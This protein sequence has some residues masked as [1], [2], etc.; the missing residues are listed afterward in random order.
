[1]D[2]REL[3]TGASIYNLFHFVIQITISD[4][5]FLYNFGYKNE[6]SK[7]YCIFVP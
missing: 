7:K 5:R 4:G 3:R 6:K 1:M 2:K